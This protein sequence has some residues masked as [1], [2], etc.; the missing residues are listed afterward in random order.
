[1]NWDGDIEWSGINEVNKVDDLVTDTSKLKEFAIKKKPTIK[2]IVESQKKTKYQQK[3]QEDTMEQL[4]YI[5]K[6]HGPFPD[7]GDYAGGKEETI[8]VFEKYRGKAEGGR[9]D[10]DNYLPGIE[11]ID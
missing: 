5:E 6:K 7:P 9:I 2:E 1:V 11:D 3:L 10:Y 4:D 8:E